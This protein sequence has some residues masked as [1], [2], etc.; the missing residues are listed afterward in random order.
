MKTF[1]LR[2]R[3]R[4][5]TLLELLFVVL[6][7][8]ILALLIL[9][10]IG[11]AKARAKSTACVNNLHQLG[12]AH[13]AF[14]HDHGDRFPFQVSTNDGGTLE[15]AQAGFA[16]SGEFFF[17]FRHFQ[18]LSNT[19][20]LPR[21]LICPADTRTNA[22]QFSSLRNVNLSYFVGVN[23]EYSRPAS[24]LAGDR[25]ISS[26]V[27]GS[28]PILR[29]NPNSAQ[30]T[31]GNHEFQGNVLF[32][33]GHVER[34]D[35]AV[36]ASTIQ[37]TGVPVN[38]LLPPVTPPG[39]QEPIASEPAVIATLQRFFDSAPGQRAGD[40][41]GNS[42]PTPSE[43][44]AATAKASEARPANV[45]VPRITA[46]A[47]PREARS[48]N[49]PRS[50]ARVPGVAAPRPAA[51]TNANTETNLSPA[52]AA[53]D[54][55]RQSKR[56]PTTAPSGSEPVDSTGSRSDFYMFLFEPGRN[57]WSWLVVLLV[58]VLAAF[59]LGWHLYRSRARRRLAAPG[60]TSRS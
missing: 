22:D 13:H 1:L 18:A 53:Q 14:A 23:A 58:A 25:N 3:V 57:I 47:A 9:P 26:D 29:L 32:A 8:G 54:A 30:W 19:L 56:A 41:A 55:A 33:D 48:P 4:G 28:S 50:V 42:S 17:A 39:G 37:S 20:E 49:D 46:P 43:S 10:V 35:N 5:T 59:S 11:K 15:F 6:I 24:I 51:L 34:S 21:L 44:P 2:P 31:S 36:L 38:N 45:N 12:I 40:S 27:F 52:L 7:I 60:I 16:M